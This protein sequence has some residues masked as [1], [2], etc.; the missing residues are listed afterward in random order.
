MSGSGGSPS[1]LLGAW[2]IRSVGAQALE[3]GREP[4]LANLA[5]GLARDLD[6]EPPQLYLVASGG[7]NALVVRSS[8]SAVAITQSLLEVYTRTELEA[9]IAH[10]LVRLRDRRR[11]RRMGLAV[12][13]GRPA[14]PPLGRPARPFRSPALGNPEP[15]GLEDDLAAVSVTGYPPALASAI[16]KAEPASGRFAP[17]WFVG[18]DPSR[19]AP[20]RRVAELSDL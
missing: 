10:C 3:D 15:V 7:P 6:A 20:E 1:R 19:P 16:L 8:G 11:M 17:L 2:V 5:A 18:T 4:R 9:V 14:R 13:L 12:A